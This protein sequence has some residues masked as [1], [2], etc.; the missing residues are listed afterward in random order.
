MKANKAP[1]PTNDRATAR[2]CEARTEHTTRLYRGKRHRVPT[3]A[4]I[5]RHCRQMAWEIDPAAET[6]H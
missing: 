5:A 2:P 3:L 1:T 6:V 4:E